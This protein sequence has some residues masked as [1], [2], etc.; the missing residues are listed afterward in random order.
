MFGVIVVLALLAGLWVVSAAAV[1]SQNIA[2]EKERIAQEEA[3]VR[4]K[5]RWKLFNRF[6][7]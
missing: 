2:N 6:A 4:T 7:K 3:T 1:T 5:E